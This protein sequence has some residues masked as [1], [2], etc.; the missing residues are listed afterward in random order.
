MS[1]AAGTRDVDGRGLIKSGGRRRKYRWS[2]FLLYAIFL[3]PKI[4]VVTLHFEVCSSHAKD[5]CRFFSFKSLH[6]F[7]LLCAYGS[8]FA[9]Q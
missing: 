3:R 2:V 9:L 5:V 4:C 8:C 1:I 7:M 6:L